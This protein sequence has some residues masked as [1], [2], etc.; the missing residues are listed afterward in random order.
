[1]S[2]ADHPAVRRFH[3]GQAARRPVP[4]A[5]PLDPEW[6]RALCLEAGADDA[7]F[8]EIERPDLEP[9]RAS[10][11]GVL[12]R[13]RTLVSVVR[14]MHPEP[15][16]SPAR[17]VANLEFHEVGHG[18]DETCR[19]IVEALAAHGVRAVNPPM[20]FPMEVTRDRI[21]VVS[22]KTVAVAAGLGRMGIHRNVI[23]PRFG[24]FVLLGTVFIDA[25]VARTGQ[26]LDGNP[27]LEC[28]LCVAACPVGAIA[29]DGRFDFTACYTHN[30]REFL[31]GFSDWV[32]TVAG[33]G[34]A[35]RYRSR[36]SAAETQSM[37]QS[38][39]F[40]PNYKSAY[41]LAVCPAGDDV[42]GPFVTDRPAFLESVVKPLQER[43]ETLYVIARSDAEAHARKRFPHK[44]VKRVHNG[45]HTRSIAGFL[46]ALPRVFQRGQARGLEAT[47]HF[48]FTG[49]EPCEATVRIHEQVL[50][51]RPGLVGTPDLRVGADSRTWLRVLSK[52]ASLPWALLR[53]RIRV[54]GRLRLMAA[55]ARCFPS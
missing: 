43:K 29:A 31:G 55:F 34:S 9:D 22:H 54:Q 41:C 1:M 6:L 46:F 16:R 19:R 18:V 30:Y 11:L 3:A 42:L 35:R 39:A 15:V 48:Q 40:G 49:D 38:L 20:A 53:G 8:V 21:W 32:E 4:P 44:T 36:V 33:S 45:L 37:W 28:K 47:Y 26:P 27:C 24:S 14:R 13:T 25:P 17:S 12:P 52:E 10:I 5:A 7:G 2:V 51:V 50:T 23:H